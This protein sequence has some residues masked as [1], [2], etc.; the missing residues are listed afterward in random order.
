MKVINR[1]IESQI[2]NLLD[3]NKV[4]LILGTRRVGKTFLINSIQKNYQS[5]LL[6][7][8]GED[9]DVQ[10]IIKNR[11]TSNYKRLVGDNK[12]IIIDEAQSIPEIGMALKLLID[13]NPNLT[14]IA[15]GSSSLDLM[16]K[17]GEPLTGRHYQFN[18]YPLSQMELMSTENFLETK[19]NLEERLIF[20]SYP[21]LINLVSNDDKRNYLQQLVQSYLL[22]DILSFGGIK[23]SD[24]IVSLLRLIAYQVGSEVSYNELGTQLGMSRLTV[25][26]YLDLL[27][28]VFII[29]KLP[30]YSTNQRKEVTKSSKWYFLDNGIRN[31]II[32]DFRIPTLRN[33][34][35]ILWENYLVSERIKSNKYLNQTKEIYFWR[36]YN[37]Q[38]VDLI[39]VRD[40][41]IASFEFKYSGNKKVKQPIAFK[42]LYPESTFECINKDNY[43][44]FV[45]GN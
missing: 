45:V 25:E 38:E 15:T 41:V 23:H 34:I 21:E 19:Q 35:G 29:Y 17:T 33:D 44:D 12:L 11:S 10:E 42:T 5:K 37:Q 40:G 43:L 2:T 9:F 1:I 31:A 26:S 20:G 7:L 16:N 13:T 27:S 3:S 32:N 39:E 22:K 6:F 30:S 24:K 28:K 8:N 14:I 36:N 4:I 18:L